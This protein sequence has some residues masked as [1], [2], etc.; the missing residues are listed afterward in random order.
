MI[1]TKP[2]DLAEWL[3]IATEGI[4][5]AGKERI[6]R[7]I[8][9]HYAEAVE[10]HLAKGE[11]ESFAQTNAISDLGDANAA[12]KRFR[13]NHFTEKEVRSIASIRKNAAKPL[14]LFVN[15]LIPWV[16]YIACRL[17][18][19]APKHHLY[20]F[21]FLFPLVALAVLSFLIARRP[22]TNAK[23]FWL[24][25]VELANHLTFVV[26]MLAWIIG[27]GENAGPAFFGL[28]MGLI[29]TV[30]PQLPL[31]NKARKLRF[32]TQDDCFGSGPL[33]D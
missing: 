27:D 26:T 8:E 5:A 21:V 29:P 28:T 1:P 17:F 11:S 13:K 16:F 4:A 18:F 32:G 3:E 14:S 20:F 33:P 10:A 2:S 24:L 15:L 7:E 6:T 30:F 12:A 23:V 9:A 19:G 31:W 25:L 22:I